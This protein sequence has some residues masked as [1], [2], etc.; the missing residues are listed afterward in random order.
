MARQFA[1]TWDYRCPFARNAHE[2]LV[3]GLQDGREWE[4]RFW[5][6]S[7]DQVHVEEGETPVWQRSL[8]EPHG[9]GGVRALL[10]GIAVR[11]AFPDRFFDFHIAA[12]RARHDE[13]KKIAEEAVLRGVA[14]SVGLDPDAVAE[15]VASGRPL[16]ALEAEHTEAVD[17][18]AVFGVPT[19]IEGDE[20]VFVRIME[21]GNVDDFAQGLGLVDSTCLNE[22]KRTRIP[23]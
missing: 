20:A 21:R 11:D 18:W 7:L 5:P 17:R 3:K 6:F 19:I 22:F 15:E 10:W 12:F 13:G 1:V 4:V 8:D 23:R 16:K 2:A 9:M 14:E